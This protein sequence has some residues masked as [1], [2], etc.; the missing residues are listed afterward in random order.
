VSIRI[1]IVQ[2]N[3]NPGK[4]DEN[5][6]KA[7]FFAQQCLDQNADVILFHEELL[8]GYC[9]DAR[10]LAEPLDGPTTLAFQKLLH[11]RDAHIVYGLTEIDSGQCFISAPVV[12]SKGVIAN[13]RK[14]HL[15]WNAQGLRHEPT[16]FHPGD[17]LVTFNLRGCTCGIMICYD[18]DFP[19]MTR[20]YADLGCSLLFWMNNRRSRGHAEVKDLAARNSMIIAASCCCGTD[21]TGAICPGGSNITD[22]NGVLLAEIWNHEGIIVGDVD[23]GKALELRSRNPWY[24]GR[25]PD[26][27]GVRATS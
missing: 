15:W 11:G 4:P 24:Q 21:E 2:Q 8:L 10:R 16:H 5:R 3:G 6:S 18:G 20:A 19:E 1:A 12:S 26:L 13:Y 17:R 9:P 14:T 7:L 22:A 23:P 25:R 27:Y